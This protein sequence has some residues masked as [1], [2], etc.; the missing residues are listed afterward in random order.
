MFNALQRFYTF[1]QHEIFDFIIKKIVF[2]IMAGIVSF[3]GFAWQ[4]IQRQLHDMHNTINSA[5]IIPSTESSMN[6]YTIVEKMES[7]LLSCKTQGVFMGWLLIKPIYDTDNRKCS[8][9]SVCKVLYYHIYFDTLRGIWGNI[10]KVEDTKSSNPYYKRQDL[11]LDTVTRNYFLNSSL[12]VGGIVE[13]DENIA[14]NNKL[15]F[16]QEVYKN[17][18]LRNQGLTLEKI[19]IKPVVVKKD[20][21]MIFTLSFQKIPSSNNNCYDTNMQAQGVV[22]NSLSDTLLTQ[23]KLL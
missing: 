8:N 22:L 5:I 20:L 16:L 13:I 10:D 17:L 4:Y 7:I 9:D 1:I 12:Y 15:E 18:D 19:Y 11:K 3:T 14:L 23:Y 2:I 6:H 21:I